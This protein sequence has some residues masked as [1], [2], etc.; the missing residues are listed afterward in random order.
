M[1]PTTPPWFSEPAPAGG[2]RSTLRFSSLV[3]GAGG[4]GA[5]VSVPYDVEP[6]FG[7][8]RVPVRATVDGEPYRGWLVSLGGPAR[9]LRI[10][11]RVR[12]RVGK[13]PGDT[14][15]VVVQEDPR[16]RAPAVPADLRRALRSR[17]QAG[18]FFRALPPA[19]RGALVRWIQSAKRAKTRAGR[20]ARAVAKLRRG[21]REP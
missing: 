9:V 11:R 19:R 15:D 8:R 17:P 1:A 20:I 21:G 3:E 16:P 7:R 6:V 13:G 5:F 10:P 12:D 18:R 14:V 2:R 4:A